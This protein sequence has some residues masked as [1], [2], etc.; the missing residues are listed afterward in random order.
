MEARLR[1]ERDRELEVVIAR[2]QEESTSER[3]AHQHAQQRQLD[4]LEK[5]HQEELK[6]SD[7]MH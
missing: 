7:L 5:K 2:L 4:A 1:S 6:G 3:A